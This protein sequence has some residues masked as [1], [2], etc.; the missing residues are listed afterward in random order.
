MRA[1]TQEATVCTLVFLGLCLPAC[2]AE[3]PGGLAF[4][5]SGEEAAKAGFP[6][7]IEN[8][9]GHSHGDDDILEFVDDWTLTWDAYVVSLGNLALASSEGETAFDDDQIFV[10][11]LNKGDPRVAV[12]EEIDSKRWDRFSFELIQPPANAVNVNVDGAVLEQM[13]DN[14]W[15]YWVSGT[16]TKGQRTVSFTWGIDNATLLEDCSNGR[17]DTQGLVVEAGKTTEQEITV[18]VEHAFWTTLG[19]EVAQMRF[20]AIA[21]VAD[22]AGVVTWEALADQMLSDLRDH[23]GEPLTDAAGNPIVYDPGSA[24]LPRNDLQQFIRRSM[25]SQ[26]HLNGSGLCRMVARFE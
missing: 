21:A 23:D 16:A 14:G 20:D 9:H 10:V 2:T 26:A 8:D 13:R 24:T 6:V 7:M 15:T 11:D 12:F 5:V 3:G 22:D 17:D 25:A 19:T 18:H 1:R 4:R